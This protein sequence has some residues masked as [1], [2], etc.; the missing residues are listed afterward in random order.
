MRYLRRGRSLFEVA[1]DR[2][3]KTGR[4][5]TV[6]WG[7]TIYARRN[8][9]TT[10]RI[11]V[12]MNEVIHK[13]NSRRKERYLWSTEHGLGPAWSH[14]TILRALS[15]MKPWMGFSSICAAGM[16]LRKNELTLRKMK[17]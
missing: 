14:L 12:S 13:N 9:Y 7:S 8:K 1:I 6:S 2:W 5:A 15:R 11:N 17:R 16:R 4:K 10:I 3:L